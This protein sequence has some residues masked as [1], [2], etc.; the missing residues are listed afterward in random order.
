MPLPRKTDLLSES[1]R[2]WLTEEIVRAGFANYEEIAADLNARLK[3]AGSDL[4][5]Q[6][7]AIGEFGREL[8]DASRREKFVALQERSREWARGVMAEQGLDAEAQNHRVMAEMLSALAFKVM[9]AMMDDD[10]EPDTKDLQRLSTMMNNLM[11][12]AGRREDNLAA[13]D[14][15]VKQEERERLAKLGEKA[16]KKLGLS[17]ERAAELRRELL[18]VAA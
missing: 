3:A 2:D 15:R 11:S 10:A 14:E 6:K 5:I 7:S 9:S 13:R 4:R 17:K 18:G 8:K 12:S 16:G 1:H